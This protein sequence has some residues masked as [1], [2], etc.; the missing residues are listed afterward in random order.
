MWSIST[1]RG[2]E[3]LLLDKEAE[4]LIDKLFDKI[5][6]INELKIE[7]N[8]NSILEIVMW[9]DTNVEEPSPALGHDLKTIEFLFRT[10]T[11]TDVD[12][13]RFNSK[14]DDMENDDL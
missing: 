1:E 3:D 6:L 9:I 5:D 10:G 13:Y 7:Y 14:S 2:K 11:I 4:Y 8:L 12:I